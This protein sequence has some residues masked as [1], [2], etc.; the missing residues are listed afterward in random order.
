MTN[1][2]DSIKAFFL[3]LGHTILADIIT[4]LPEAQQIILQAFTAL[5]DADHPIRGKQIW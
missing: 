4:A 5:L 2:W 1:F 3:N